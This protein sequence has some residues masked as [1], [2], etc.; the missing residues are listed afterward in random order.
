M[1]SKVKFA[2]HPLHPMIVGFPITFYLV[3]FVCFAMHALGWSAFWF[4]AGV[5]ANLAGVL[6]AIAAAI[7]GF[8]DW[9]LGIPSSSRAKATGTSHMAFNVGALL[10]FA[11]NVA[12]QWRHRL[13]G[14]PPVGVSVAL[15][16]LGVA[17]TFAAGFLGWKLVQEHHVGVDL[18]PEQ[19][20]L[21]PR[22]ETHGPRFHP[23]HGQPVQ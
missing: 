4:R 18:T 21:E 11:L 2:G 12:L 22:V 15:T 13:E 1:Y 16:I 14:D 20:R 19:E 17:L 8:I 7:P 3:A 9:G 6:S 23:G 10:L 5:Y